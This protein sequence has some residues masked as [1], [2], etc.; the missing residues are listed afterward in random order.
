MKFYEI[1]I[2]QVMMFRLYTDYNKH[3]MIKVDIETRE[4]LQVLSPAIEYFCCRL[5]IRHALIY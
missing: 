1:N 3:E 4:K 2:C 5:Y